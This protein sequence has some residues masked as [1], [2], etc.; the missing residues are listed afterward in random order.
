MLTNIKDK[1]NRKRDRHENYVIFVLSYLSYKLAF[2]R[3]YVIAVIKA[4]KD[5]HLEFAKEEHL[6]HSYQKNNA[7]SLSGYGNVKRVML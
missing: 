7:D 2:T 1:A 5:R 6:K 3:S 4:Y